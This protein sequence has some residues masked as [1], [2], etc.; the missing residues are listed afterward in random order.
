MYSCLW[1]STSMAG[2]VL[3]LL[4]ISTNTENC[5]WV[6]HP[7]TAGMEEAP[8]GASG[9]FIG[10]PTQNKDSECTPDSS[11]SLVPDPSSIPFTFFVRPLPLD[12]CLSR[13]YLSAMLLALEIGEPVVEGSVRS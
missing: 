3:P 6:S 9:A 2:E 10:S 4:S 8:M 7:I 11:R 13:S 1:C 5:L 12:L